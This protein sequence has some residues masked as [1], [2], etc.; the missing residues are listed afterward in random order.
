MTKRS[1]FIGWDPREAAAFAVCRHSI[2]RH[3]SQDIPVHG[4]VLDDLKAKGL[5]QRPM[6]WRKSAL[7]KPIMWD[8]ISDAPMSTEHANARFLVKHLA[9]EG[10]AL[11]CDGDV[12]WRHDPVELFNSLDPKYAVYCVKHRH[13]PPPGIKMDGQE[14]T[15]Y[16]R[17]NW[18]SVLAINCDHVANRSLTLDVVN[19]APGRDLHRLFWIADCD[20]GE[21]DPS[22]NYLV[23]HTDPS[24]EPKAVHF[25]DGVPDMA[26]YESV[27]YAD[28]WR[29]ELNAWAS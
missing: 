19:K 9:Q 14:Q 12:L 6:E 2:K 15:R 1:I 18:T 29:E 5:Y 13:E 21:L 16:A 23:G 7:D 26:G 4:L 8:V 17:K 3:L 28:V 27:E 10:W 20:I 11:F 22:W 24:I 25:T